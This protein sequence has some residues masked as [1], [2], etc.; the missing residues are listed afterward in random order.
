MLAL[1]KCWTKDE[2]DVM[3]RDRVH[4][5]GTKDLFTECA[6]ADDKAI[7]RRLEGGVE[8]TLAD[9]PNFRFSWKPFVQEPGN[10]LFT[11]DMAVESKTFGLCCWNLGWPT[12]L[13][14]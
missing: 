4:A 7:K 8:E 12:K 10:H 9:I 6:R 5:Q 13:N 14:Q 2:Q 1:V 3:V 11:F